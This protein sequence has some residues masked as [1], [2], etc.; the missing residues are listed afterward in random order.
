MTVASEPQAPSV[1]GLMILGHGTLPQA[2]RDAAEQV[3]GSLSRPTRTIGL[4]NDA[5]LEDTAE[6]LAQELAALDT[7]AGV[8]ILVDALGAT[9]YNAARQAIR[10]HDQRRLVTG[11]NLP[12]LIRVYNY[13][14]LALAELAEA[15]VAGGQ[16][17]IADMP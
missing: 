1:A 2:L 15:A 17:G 10:G 4:A 8:L 5:A 11:L 3:L 13:S 16:R 14:N 9:P 6:H 7:G 12:M